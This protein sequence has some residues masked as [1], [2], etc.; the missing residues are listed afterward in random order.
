MCPF[1]EETVNDLYFDHDKEAKADIP[2]LDEW[3]LA[4][5]GHY[6]SYTSLVYSTDKENDAH[7]FIA[8]GEDQS[9]VYFPRF[10]PECGKRINKKLRSTKNQID[11]RIERPW[12][13]TA[14]FFWKEP[15]NES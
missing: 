4:D 14:Y 12:K 6:G 15:K 2:Y 13:S 8:T 10:C 3:C 1:C 7:F 11:Y 9:A 5:D